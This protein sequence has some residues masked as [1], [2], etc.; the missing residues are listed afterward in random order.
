MLHD[1]VDPPF[2][3][4]GFEALREQ[5]S[6]TI[7]ENNLTQLAAQALTAHPENLTEILLTF[8]ALWGE[9]FADQDLAAN[10]TVL[11]AAIEPKFIKETVYVYPQPK[12]KRADRFWMPGWGPGVFGRHFG[13]RQ[14]R[15]GQGR[16][17]G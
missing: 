6:E 2:F 14:P 7:T 17:D 10:V 15:R 4:I 8:M 3:Q 12:E 11:A 5:S 13:G 1:D 16:Q 9:I